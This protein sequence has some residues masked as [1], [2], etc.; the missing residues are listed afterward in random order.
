MSEGNMASFF[1]A[2]ENTTEPVGHTTLFRDRSRGN[3]TYY[4]D[5]DSRQ[6]AFRNL[7]PIVSVSNT[8]NDTWVRV[9]HGAETVVADMRFV[10]ETEGQ[11]MV[12]DVMETLANAKNIILSRR[13]EFD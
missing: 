2:L 1:K 7:L 10:C 8:P 12:E 11:D 6:G 13:D 5:T 3:C 4:R 9:Y